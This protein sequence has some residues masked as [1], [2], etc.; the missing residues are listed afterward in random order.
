MIYNRKSMRL[1]GYD[2]SKDGY[3]FVTI[4]TYG[5]IHYFDND[6]SKNIIIKYWHKLNE[7]FMNVALDEYIIMPYH[8]HG[9]IIINNDILDELNEYP[10]RANT[11]VRPYNKQYQNINGMDD[12]PN[13][14]HKNKYD[15]KTNV[16]ADPCVC[17]NILQ[18]SSLKDWSR[19]M[20][21]ITKEQFEIVLDI[22]EKFVPNCEVRVFGSRYKG[23]A[24]KYSDLD[25]AIVEN[26]KLSWKL[27]ADIREA[28]EESELPFRVDVIDWNSI[29]L[30]FKKIIEEGYEVIKVG[31]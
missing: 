12:P 7:K 18:K 17:P 29:S 4:C 11:C 9:I 3:Y 25:L 14:T 23:N 16:G 26:E 27:I 2:Y 10:S 13:H 1:K 30:E 21:D 28:F 15:I 20:I 6:V 31:R 5:K 22:L 19:K 8:F 24:Q